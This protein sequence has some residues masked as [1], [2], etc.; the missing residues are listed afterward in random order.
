[1][2]LLI[3]AVAVAA[4]VFME[5]RVAEAARKERRDREFELWY[6]GE[7]DKKRGRK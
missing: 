6:C 1:M 3:L 5:W 7:R 4:V 2:I